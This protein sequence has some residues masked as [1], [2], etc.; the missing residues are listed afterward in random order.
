MAV[1]AE[2]KGVP[3]PTPK[4]KCPV[5][6]MFVAKYPDW[7]ASISFRDG[8]RVYFDGPKDMFKFSMDVKRFAPTRS[9]A[10]IA[11]MYVM[12]Y[13]GLTPLDAKMAFYV[14]ESD[15]FGPMG[16]EL[17][18][19]ERETDAKEFLKDHKGKRILKSTE[20]TQQVIKGLDQ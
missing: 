9:Q 10:D 2:E 6:G 16:K 20:V 19:F 1:A 14:V 7:I 13:Y 3:K 5:C 12:D 8:S 15:V 18:P 11:V 17:I 4:D